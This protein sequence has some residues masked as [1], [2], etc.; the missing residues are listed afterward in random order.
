[1]CWMAITG[2]GSTKVAYGELRNLQSDRESSS[3]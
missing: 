3:G 2:Q 1:M